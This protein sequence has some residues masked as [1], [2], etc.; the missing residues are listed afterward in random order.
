M[1]PAHWYHIHCGHGHVASRWEPVVEE[2]FKALR[3]AKFD[4]EIHV[5]LVGDLKNRFDVLDLIE[6]LGGDLEWYVDA[7]ADEGYEQVT[8][9]AMHEFAKTAPADQPILYCHTKSAYQDTPFNR[10]WRRSMT[11]HLVGFDDVA[12]WKFAVSELAAD[13][14]DLVACHWLTHEEFPVTVSEGKPMPGGNFWWAT[15]GYLAGLPPVEGGDPNMG[16][17]RYKAEEW[18]G[19]NSPRVLDLKRGWPNYPLED[20]GYDSVLGGRL[21]A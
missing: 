12:T 9:Q 3:A 14:Y 17:N 11:R 2:H 19:K 1:Y 5:G 16:Y 7:E 10:A 18:V 21:H 20:G 8:I 13:R 15:A 4:G 6:K